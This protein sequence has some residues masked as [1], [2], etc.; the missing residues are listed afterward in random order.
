MIA[1]FE[2]L[3]HVVCRQPHKAVRHH[4]RNWG[5]VAA[6]AAAPASSRASPTWQWSVLDARARTCFDTGHL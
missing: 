3:A 5:L 2:A 1:D 4:R 6:R